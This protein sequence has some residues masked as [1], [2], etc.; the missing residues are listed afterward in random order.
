MRLE[1][2]IHEFPFEDSSFDRFVRFYHK[3]VERNQPE[4]HAL[5]LAIGYDLTS[6]QRSPEKRKKHRN[7]PWIKRQNGDQWFAAGDDVRSSSCYLV[8]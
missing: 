6:L 4:R 8:G 2:I 5:K 1:L 3:A 7:L